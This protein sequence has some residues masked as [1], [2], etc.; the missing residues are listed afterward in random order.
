MQP[1]SPDPLRLSSAKLTQP[2]N[3]SPGQGSGE[4]RLWVAQSSPFSATIFA[5]VFILVCLGER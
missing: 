3:H 4:P 1:S 2:Q 5:S